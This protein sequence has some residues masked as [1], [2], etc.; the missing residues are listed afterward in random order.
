MSTTTRC[1]YEENIRKL[2][3][4]V[5]PVNCCNTYVCHKVDTKLTCDID[6]NTSCPQDRHFTSSFCYTLH[7]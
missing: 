7:T 3:E 2:P 1:R 5:I 4:R 6:T